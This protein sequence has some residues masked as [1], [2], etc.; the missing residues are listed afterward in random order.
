MTNTT[1]AERFLSEP[2]RF[3][4]THHIMNALDARELEKEQDWEA[5]TTTWTFPDGSKIQV[6]GNDVDIVAK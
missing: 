4:E 3:R 6:C 5:E 1:D 2:N